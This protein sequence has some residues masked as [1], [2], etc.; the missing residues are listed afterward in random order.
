MVK[1]I[2]TSCAF[3]PYQRDASRDHALDELNYFTSM[4]LLIWL[5]WL[6]KLTRSSFQ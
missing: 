2:A 5:I 3:R 1:P 4:L 6:E